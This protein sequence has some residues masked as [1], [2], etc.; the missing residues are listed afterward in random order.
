MRREVVSATVTVVDD[1]S[2][3]WLLL[4]V[5]SVVERIDIDDEEEVRVS[6]TVV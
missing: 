1:E 3:G 5:G 6:A 2:V 4:C